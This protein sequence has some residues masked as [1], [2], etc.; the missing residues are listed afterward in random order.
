MNK[1]LYQWKWNISY[2]VLKWNRQIELN[3]LNIW[4]FVFF[5]YYVFNRKSFYSC[6]HSLSN[7]TLFYV[8]QSPRITDFR[9]YLNS[10]GCSYLDGCVCIG[11]LSVVATPFNLELWNFGIT[12]LMWIS[13]KFQI[14][15]KLFLCR[16][17][18]LFLYFFKISL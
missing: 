11:V 14:F 5:N 8:C 10:V 15:E 4:Y 18:A 7:W 9:Y 12:F 2:L 17:I 6:F 3:E 16:V 1:W 13:K